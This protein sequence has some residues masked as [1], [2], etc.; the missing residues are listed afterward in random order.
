MEACRAFGITGTYI[1]TMVAGR[2]L[3]SR[4]AQ[5]QRPETPAPV[6]LGEI[7]ESLGGPTFHRAFPISSVAPE[8]R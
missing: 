4:Q 5:S 2:Q 6:Y 8:L 1:G 7:G 3:I